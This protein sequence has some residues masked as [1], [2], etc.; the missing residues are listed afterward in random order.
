MYASSDWPIGMCIAKMIFPTASF[1]SYSCSLDF[2]LFRRCGPGGMTRMIFF[3]AHHTHNK[4]QSRAFGVSNCSFSRLVLS[5]DLGIE[6]YL[7]RSAVSQ[8]Q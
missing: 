3:L 1:G 8:R 2:S 4:E 6:S 7:T 5:D